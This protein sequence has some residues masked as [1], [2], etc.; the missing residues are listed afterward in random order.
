[1]PT[2]S[3]YTAYTFFFAGLKRVNQDAPVL[4][5]AHGT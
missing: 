1:M 2:R 3:L 5:L 4:R